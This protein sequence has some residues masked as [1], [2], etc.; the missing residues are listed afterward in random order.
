[1]RFVVN[2]RGD[3]YHIIEELVCPFNEKKD[4]II[5]KDGEI[6]YWQN[7]NNYYRDMKLNVEMMK[8]YISEIEVTKWR[9]EERRQKTLNFSREILNKM[10]AYKRE[11]K[12]DEVLNKTRQEDIL[13]LA[14]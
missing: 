14:C 12:I 10:I 2:S 1:M 3:Y 4:Y 8:E 6:V 11:I 9:S 5:L 7:A 13:Y